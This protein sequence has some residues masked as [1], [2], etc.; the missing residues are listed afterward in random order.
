MGH[1][2]HDRV[3]IM[4]ERMKLHYGPNRI[5]R[6]TKEEIDKMSRLFGVTQGERKMSHQIILETI[7]NNYVRS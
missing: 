4:L 1:T 6:M 2:L 7:I 5:K 3:G